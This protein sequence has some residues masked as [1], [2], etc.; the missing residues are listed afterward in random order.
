MN[1]TIS[2]IDLQQ[3]TNQIL[4]DVENKHTP[5]IIRRGDHPSV[6][7]I[8]YNDFLKISSREEIVAK[9]NKTWAK[10]ESATQYS[11]KEIEADLNEATR[12]L[13]NNARGAKMT[14]SVI[15]TNVLIRALIRPLGTVGHC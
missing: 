2:V 13:R 6:V 14:R 7:M 8:S 10:S 5:Y 1:K 12:E 3:K 15:D 4:D 9:F 11:D